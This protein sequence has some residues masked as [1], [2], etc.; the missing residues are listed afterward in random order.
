MGNMTE[1][2]YAVEERNEYDY[3]CNHAHEFSKDE[4]A[5]IIKEF[6]Y[7]LHTQEERGILGDV[8]KIREDLVE[9]FEELADEEQRAESYYSCY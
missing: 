4:L 3:I 1:F 8:S 6:A 7:A 2:Y 5:D 9:A